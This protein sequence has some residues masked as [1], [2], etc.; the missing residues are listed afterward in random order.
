MRL[1][2]SIVFLSLL[3]VLPG[4]RAA[5]FAAQEHALATARIEIA[6]QRFRVQIADTPAARERG[7]MNRS[8]LPTGAGMLFVFAESGL[9][10]FW[11]KNTLIPLDMVWID[12]NW[13]IVGI[14]KMKPCGQERSRGN[15]CPLYY[16]P[17][18]IRYALEVN[19]GEAEGC[20]G[21]VL[22]EN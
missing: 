13:Q 9:H 10:P 11:M 4:G 17:A 15:D 7:L 16:P 1:F 5:G 18:P 14:T 8:Q 2:C 22:L 3:I 21:T 19:T 12:E 20:S 6:G